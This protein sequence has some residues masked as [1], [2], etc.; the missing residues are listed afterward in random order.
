MFTP[1]IAEMITEN[2]IWE[3]LQGKH[4]YRRVIYRLENLGRKQ[5][6][7][8]EKHH[9]EP[10]RVREVWLKPL[11]HLAIHIAHA[12]VE[13]SGPFYAKVGAFVR[14]FPGSYHRRILTLDP[15]LQ[16]ALLSLG[17]KRPGRG[18][19]LNKHPNTLAANKRR[20]ERQNQSSAENGRKG[21]AKVSEKLKG[22]EISWGDKIS[23]TKKA[24]P[25]CSC[26]L[27]GLEM[28]ALLSNIIQHQRSKKCLTKRLSA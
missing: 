11:E 12:F 2:Y 14:P 10:E 22:R 19:N 3:L 27:C 9:I 28:K 13:K 7:D 16:A 18:V 4:D 15:G 20:T 8:L 17:Q 1:T 24:A 6:P 26:L 21:A 25:M 5:S 23:A